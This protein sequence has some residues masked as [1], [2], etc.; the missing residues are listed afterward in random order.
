MAI[1]PERYDVIVVGAGHAGIEAALA[2]A[3]MGGKVLVFTL[4]IDQIGQMSCNPAIGGLAKSHLV[5]EIDALGGEIAKAADETGLQFK[6][7]NTSKGPAVWALRSQNDRKAYRERMKRVMEEEKNVDI[8]QEEVIEILTRDGRAVGVRTRTGME[9]SAGSVVLTTGTFLNGLIHIGMVSFPAGR[10]GEFAAIDLSQSLKNIGLKLGRFK[11]GTSPRIDIRTVDLSKMETQYGDEPPRG[12]SFRYPTLEVKQI[13]CYITRTTPETHKIIRESLAFSP[14]YTGKIVGIGPRYCPSIEVKIVE[15]PERDTHRVILE[16]EGRDT[17]EYYLNGLATSI[18]EDY[19]IK[20]LRSIPGLEKV[21]ILRPGYAIEYDYVYPN[22]LYPWLETKII[23][24]LF[25]AGQINGT[26]GYEEAAAQGFIAGVNALLRLDNREF[27][28][29]RHEAYIG[30]LIDDLITKGTD[31]P[32]RLFTSRAE[33]RLLLRMDNAR[34]RLM[35]Y[36]YE[37]GLIKKSEYESF[38]QEKELWEGELERLRNTRMKPKEVNAKLQE[39][40]LKPLKDAITLYDFL[41]RPE[42]SYDT[43][44]QL[45]FGIDFP[46]W[47]KE[48]IEIEIKYEGY[49]KRMEK[50]AK[51]YAEMD[52][53]KIP[54]DFDFSQVES[55]SNEA[56]EKLIRYKPL[57]LGQ[58][59]RVPGVSPS[60]ILAIFYHLEKMRTLK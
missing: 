49:I 5:K 54:E 14:L 28:L 56:K 24:N 41:K 47:V 17:Y 26:S 27:T 34:D 7:L 2:A 12:F 8:I 32:Y 20:M 57:T 51:K 30:V 36:G 60:D 43:L 10:A 53:I 19:Q 9:Y 25:L 18:P 55:V 44:L 35:K 45:G 46:F 1:Y 6:M 38:L 31:E 11:T 23:K 13:P 50:E 22:Q 3:R 48:R 37:L 42:I 4:N 52:N 21:K 59:S 40:G 39:M 29:G 16:P 58:A 33:F 15:F